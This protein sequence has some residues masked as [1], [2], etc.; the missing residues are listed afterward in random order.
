L[1]SVALLLVTLVS[2]DWIEEVFGVDPDGGNGMLEWGIV[3]GL[4]AA[5]LVSI[6]LAMREWRRVRAARA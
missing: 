6:T 1:L 5:A 3:I 2:A 4:A